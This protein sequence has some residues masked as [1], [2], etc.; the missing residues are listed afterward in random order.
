MNNRKQSELLNQTVN[1]RQALTGRN[2]N[3]EEILGLFQRIRIS[4]NFVYDGRLGGFVKH[5]RRRIK[6]K[7]F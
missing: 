5:G 1:M 2:L 4:D 3:G 6:R 7:F